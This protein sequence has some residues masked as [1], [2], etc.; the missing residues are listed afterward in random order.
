M[1]SSQ[2]SYIHQQKSA[3]KGYRDIALPSDPQNSDTVADSQ[4]QK[5]SVSLVSDSLGAH[6]VEGWK[7]SELRVVNIITTEPSFQS[8][9]FLFSCFFKG[10]RSLPL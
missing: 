7:R 3:W 4:V 1:S 10:K 5:A 8:C 6:M 2:R 9:L